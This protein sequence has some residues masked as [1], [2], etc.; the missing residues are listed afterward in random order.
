MSVRCLGCGLEYAG[1]KG[2]R[3]LFA[4]P[5]S[6]LRPGFLR[7]L[8]EVK[9]FHR[10]AKA[11]LRAQPEGVEPTLGEFLADGRYSRFFTEHF[12]VPLV[13]AVWSTG[14]MLALSY[15]ARYLFRFLEHHGML[16]VTGSPSWKTVCGGSARYVDKTV[17]QLTAVHLST[18]VRAIRRGV[19]SVALWDSEG[20]R[21]EVDRVVIATHPNQALRMLQD[22]TAEERAVLG[23]IGYSVNETVLHRDTSLLPASQAARSSWNYLVSGCSGGR[24][25]GGVPVV[26]YH[27]NRLHRLESAAGDY[28]VTLN[29]GELI[30]PST[31]IARMTYEHPVYTPESVAAQA[32]LPW[33]TAGRT[34]FAGAYHGWGFHEDGCASG[35]AAAAAFGVKW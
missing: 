6:L 31:V 33:L 25:T 5:S 7:M 30:D 26:S 9:R 12:M 21:H 23:A 11:L 10:D 15:P 4:Q 18:P 3:G 28:V 13:S 2:A 34:A 1:A 27:M 14:P 35:V 22:A 19:E 16:A 20:L 29:G 24:R 32:R 8:T 17:K